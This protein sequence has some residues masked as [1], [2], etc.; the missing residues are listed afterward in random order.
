M[1]TFINININVRNARMTYIVKR[2]KYNEREAIDPARSPAIIIVADGLEQA[3]AQRCSATARGG[4]Q[5]EDAIFGEASSGIGG[6][7]PRHPGSSGVQGARG[8]GHGDGVFTGQI[9]WS[10]GDLFTGNHHGRPRWSAAAALTREKAR[11]E[12]GREVSA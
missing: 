12:E 1:S 9:G 7:R 4:T 10:G 8:Q 11:S 6:A 3:G 5:R 2:R